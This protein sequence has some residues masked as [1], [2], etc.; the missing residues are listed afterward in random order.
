[1]AD[2]VIVE[3]FD[4]DAAV[5]VGGAAGIGVVAQAILGAQ[6]AVDAIEDDVQ[7]LRS[8]GEED[9]AAS[10]VRDGFEG[11]FAGGVAAA[12][13]FYRANQNGVEKGIGANGGFAGGF[14]IGAAGGFSDVGGENDHA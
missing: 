4:F 14:E 11:V 9:G 13:A 3:N 2:L 6:L 5:G 8:V 10:G 7:V 1:M 12:F